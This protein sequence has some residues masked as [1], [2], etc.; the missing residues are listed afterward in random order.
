MQGAHLLKTAHLTLRPFAADDL[1]D[2]HRL[3]THPGVRKYLWDDKVISV[4]RAKE[5]IDASLGRFEQHGF[6]HWALF[7][8]NE[9][10]L[11]GFCGLKPWAEPATAELLYAVAPA[12]WGRG[13]AVE[14]SR[15]VL[16]FGFED[17]GL[18][19][20]WAGADPPN[21]A[22]FRVME[23]LGMSFAKRDH[24]NGLEVVYYRLTKE[25]FLRSG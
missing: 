3:W 2:L 10:K 8:T 11:I 16:R 1:E 20:V 9:R 23:K 5:E 12:C 13:L 22:S 7:P 25:R 14:A 6:G 17:Q 24:V 15:A 4:D 18:K 21:A 19:Q